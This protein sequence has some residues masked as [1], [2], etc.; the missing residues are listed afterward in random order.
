[1]LPYRASARELVAAGWNSLTR[2]DV[3]IG[4]E[5][6]SAGPSFGKRSLHPGNLPDPGVGKGQ[7]FA[8]RKRYS[9]G[10]VTQVIGRR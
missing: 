4:P 8:D 9:T 5:G 10:N 6:L 3:S 1:M 2:P 7:F